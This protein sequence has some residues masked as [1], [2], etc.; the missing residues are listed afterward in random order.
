VPDASVIVIHDAE[1]F[2]LSQLH[3]L[4][5][6]VGRSDIKSYCFLMTKTKDSKGLERLK[7]IKDNSDGFKISEYDY[8]MRGAGDFM[9]DKQSGKFMH[10]LGHLSYNT[11]SIFLAKKLSDEFFDSGK[12]IEIV[13]EIALKKYEKIKDITLN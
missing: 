8:K 11:E 9:G 4:R 13:R 7:V 12:N 2:G 1:R 10:D 5:G 6:R 3:Q